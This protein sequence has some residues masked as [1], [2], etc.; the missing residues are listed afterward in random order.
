MTADWS[1]YEHTVDQSSLS[2][3]GRGISRLGETGRSV[4]GEV[5]L[6]CQLQDADIMGIGL[7]FLVIETLVVG[8]VFDIDSFLYQPSLPALRE[9][10][11]TNSDLR[12]ELGSYRTLLSLP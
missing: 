3:P 7:S 4:G 1:S 2:I 9:F 8:E 5:H 10:M 6:L 11:F 12:E